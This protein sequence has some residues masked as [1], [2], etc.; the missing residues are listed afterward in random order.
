MPGSE[1][2]WKKERLSLAP[3]YF[4]PS[5][6]GAVA[7]RTGSS[8]LAT[9]VVALLQR[10]PNVPLVPVDRSLAQ[11]SASLAAQLHLR[12]ADAVYAALAQRLGLPRLDPSFCPWH[13]LRCINSWQYC[14]FQVLRAALDVRPE[15]RSPALAAGRPCERKEPIGCQSVASQRFLL[16]IWKN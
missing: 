4:F 15:I 12:G 3:P 10:L 8:A 14:R 11:R 6:Q 2:A 9:R 1:S 13:P 7:R 16:P 5:W